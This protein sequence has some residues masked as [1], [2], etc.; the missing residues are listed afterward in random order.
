MTPHEFWPTAWELRQRLGDAP[1]DATSAAAL[2]VP[3]VD[4][5]NMQWYLFREPDRIDPAWLAEFIRNGLYDNPPSVER[6]GDSLRA[7]GWPALGFLKHHVGNLTPAVTSVVAEIDTENWWVIADAL[8]IAV[9]LPSTSSGPIILNLLDQWHRSPVNWMRGELLVQS[10]AQLAEAPSPS[11]AVEQAVFHIASRLLSDREFEYEFEQEVSAALSNVADELVPAVLDGIESALALSG[12][13]TSPWIAS[14]RNQLSDPAA[15]LIQAWVTTLDREEPGQ[16]LLRAARLCDSRSVS[17]RAMGWRS[18][19]RVLRERPQAAGAQQLLLRGA[20]EL[21]TT[22]DHLDQEAVL[23]LVASHFRYVGVEQRQAILLSMRQRAESEDVV[24]RYFARDVFAALAGAVSA[25]DEILLSGLVSELGRPRTPQDNRVVFADWVGRTSAVPA[26]TLLRMSAAE[27]RGMIE[28]PPVGAGRFYSDDYSLEGF[29]EAL[30]RCVQERFQELL[31]ELSNFAA[32]AGDASV[33]ASLVW[34]AREA[35]RSGATPDGGQP[36]LVEFL[37]AMSR[38]VERLL[39]IE[40]PSEIPRYDIRSITRALADL[41]E[42]SAE[43]LFD[44]RDA[45]AA[46][47]TEH[48]SWLFRSTDPDGQYESQYGGTNM[49]PP[50]LAL[51]STRGTALLA[52][53]AVLSR[54][55]KDDDAASDELTDGIQDLVRANSVSERSPSVMSGY[56]RYLAQLSHYWPDFLDEHEGELLPTGIDDSEIWEAVFVTHV[57]FQQPNRSVANRLAHHFEIAVGRLGDEQY[58]YLA[59]S[60]DS[61]ITHLIVLAMPRADDSMGW[62]SLLIRALGQAPE[63]E[64]AKALDDLAHAVRQEPL[65]IPAG[66][67][68]ALIADRVRFVR[69]DGGRNEEASALMR[70]TMAAKL[71]IAEVAG[72]LITLIELGG[73]TGARDLVQFLSGVAD[74]EC[75]SAASVLICAVDNGMFDR[76]TYFPEDELV[77]LL[78]ILGDHAPEATWDLVN[79][80]GQAGMFTVEDLATALHTSSGVVSDDASQKRRM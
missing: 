50:T 43:W 13:T 22:A 33:G 42:E 36:A 10:V 59:S 53:F 72:L 28:H 61:V 60:A 80:L 4:D 54:R 38:Y 46:P 2:I 49:D 20:S 78:T 40:G 16:S 23:Q 66:W 34:G 14:L 62:R 11:S 27:L 73:R 58:S 8:D 68:K 70:L 3:V 45:I 67:F 12:R 75:Q 79:R 65:D 63:S 47:L 35:I 19:D 48:L 29:T 5:F 30:R 64:S 1:E 39:Q 21:I 76:A 26:E 6:D 17:R 25:D 9:L 41:V 51:N 55:W 77:L 15:M 74:E 32:L 37:G 31:P 18:L 56:G 52:A 69:E 7:A 44:G 71:P 24:D 57:R